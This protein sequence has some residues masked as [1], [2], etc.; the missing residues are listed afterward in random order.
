M[1]GKDKKDKTAV[2]KQDRRFWSLSHGNTLELL[3]SSN[4]Q[5][6]HSFLG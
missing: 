3:L 6:L 5:Q 4:L 2:K 1:K